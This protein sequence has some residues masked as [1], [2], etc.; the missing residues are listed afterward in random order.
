MIGLLAEYDALPGVSYD[1]PGANGHGCGHNLYSAGAFGT[2]AVLKEI[3][4]TYKIPGTIKVF[5]TPA[6]ET[7]DGKAWMGKQGALLRAR[8][9][10]PLLCYTGK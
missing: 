2:A 4:E 10:R 1:N 3:I 5:R 7:Y 8:N 6:E 9:S